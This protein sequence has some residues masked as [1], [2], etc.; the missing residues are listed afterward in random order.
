VDVEKTGGLTYEC[1]KGQFKF[2]TT[3]NAGDDYKYVQSKQSFPVTESFTLEA[4]L[5]SEVIPSKTDQNNYG[6]IFG[7]DEK[8]TYSLRF[9]GQYYRFEKNL[10]EKNYLSSNEEIHVSRNWN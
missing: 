10:V 5:S 1:T 8:H 7:V 6:F 9:K 4:D 3:P 2:L